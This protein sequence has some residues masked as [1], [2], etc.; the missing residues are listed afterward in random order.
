MDLPGILVP[1]TLFVCI[2]Y[3]IKAVVDAYV[4]RKMVE[5]N[6]SQELLKS[7]LEG[8]E[9]RRRHGSLRWG[10]VLVALA[11]GFAIIEAFGW[12]EPTPG[13]FAVLLG[14]TGLGNLA[15]YFAARR[16]G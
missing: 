10:V 16:L 15:Y 14:A 8:E 4:R 9:G 6:G 3:A 2:T 13:I 5:S 1:I 7:I 11:I 12:R